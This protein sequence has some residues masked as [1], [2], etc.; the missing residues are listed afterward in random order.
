MCFSSCFK[1]RL[2][3]C[4]NCKDADGDVEINFDIV[5]WVLIF[6]YQEFTNVINN[7]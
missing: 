4:C 7:Y 1:A 6:T 2:P 5:A 3:Y